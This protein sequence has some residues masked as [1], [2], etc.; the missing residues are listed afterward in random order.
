MILGK[1][2]IWTSH[3][4]D[5]NFLTT[6]PSIPINSSSP[7]QLLAHFK[8]YLTLLEGSMP[9]FQEME[10]QF[11]QFFRLCLRGWIVEQQLYK[12][13]QCWC[14]LTRFA[15]WYHL[16]LLQKDYFIK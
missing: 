10:L 4:A 11:D 16:F 3:V 13:D 14:L 7:D 8:N 12:Y 6:T 9:R 5:A 2:E 1:V 15:K